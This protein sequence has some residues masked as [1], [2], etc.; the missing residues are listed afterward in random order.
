M[1]ISRDTSTPSPSFKLTIFAIDCVVF[2]ASTNKFVVVI[3]K[4]QDEQEEVVTIKK[5][6]DIDVSS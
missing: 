6:L 1:L 3:K 5:T 2:V 4:D